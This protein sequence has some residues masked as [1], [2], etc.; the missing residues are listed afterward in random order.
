MATVNKSQRCKVDAIVDVYGS[1]GEAPTTDTPRRV[2]MSN[3]PITTTTI[4]KPKTVKRTRVAKAKTPVQTYD[5]KAVNVTELKAMANLLGYS[6]AIG[7]GSARWQLYAI[8]AAHGIPSN[9]E[10]AK[11]NALVLAQSLMKSKA[12]IMTTTPK[13]HYAKKTGGVAKGYAEA[14][15]PRRFGERTK[16]GTGWTLICVDHNT[17]YEK[18]STECAIG[19]Q[20]D[21]QFL[22]DIVRNAPAKVKAPR[23]RRR[24]KVNKEAAEVAV[25]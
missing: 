7:T 2:N 22:I 12:I 11:G 17:R 1:G 18:C 9:H 3:E 23:A 4:E 6:D 10:Q 20:K 24:S 15:N 5:P 16:L 21:G 13:L 14:A 19:P 8:T 25:N